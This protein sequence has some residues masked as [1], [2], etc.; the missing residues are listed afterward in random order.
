MSSLLKRALQNQMQA[1]FS[2]LD[3]VLRGDD[4]DAVHDMRVASRRLQEILQ[5]VLPKTDDRADVLGEIR[6]AR[7]L[8]TLARDVDVVIEI[9]GNSEQ[10][11]VTSDLDRG[12][13][14]L[15]THL[16]SSRKKI[17]AD[18]R[19]G[20]ERLKLRDS[21]IRLEALLDECFSDGPNRE[22][23]VKRIAS[24][25]TRREEKFREASALAR[26][27]RL[28]KDL[29][30]VRIS[31]KRL[32]YILEVAEGFQTHN[33][34]EQI[35]RLKVLQETL[36][37][38]HDLEV[39]EDILIDFCSEKRGIRRHTS[40][41]RAL[42]GLILDARKDKADYVSAFLEADEVGELR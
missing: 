21:K 10:E 17:Q 36:G 28:P 13:K 32:R 23:V 27:T 7:R 41:F 18:L 14:L 37:K 35:S 11:E 6:K 19:E 12:V 16:R 9:I 4:P 25:L 34:E 1:F 40:A 8:Q 42:Y 2:P 38:W 15:Q 22:T 33:V 20:L 39:L 31:A 5:V 26:K 24:K 29:H 30:K 3:A